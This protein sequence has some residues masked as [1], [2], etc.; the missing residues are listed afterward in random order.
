M[1][2]NIGIDL[3]STLDRIRAEHKQAQKP[4]KKRVTASKP[5]DT[6]SSDLELRL[7]SLAGEENTEESV[8]LEMDVTTFIKDL[9]G[10]GKKP[11]AVKFLNDNK[12]RFTPTM[13]DGLTDI[14]NKGL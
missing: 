6:R 13:K 1:K 10:A 12:H 8:Q 14:I 3:T 9:F 4:K 7:M 5:E 2:I 11:Q